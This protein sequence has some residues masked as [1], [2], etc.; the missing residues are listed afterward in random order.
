MLTKIRVVSHNV[1]IRN[2]L[3]S[4]FYAFPDRMPLKFIHTVNFTELFRKIVNGFWLGTG[5]RRH[6]VKAIIAR[7]RA[8]YREC[9]GSRAA[10]A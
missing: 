7:L 8:G 2:R 5:C 4:R 9:A 6:P 3:R 10:P 1:N